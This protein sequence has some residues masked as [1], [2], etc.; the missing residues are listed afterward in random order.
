MEI[1]R[2]TAMNHPILKFTA[3]LACLGAAQLA[4]MLGISTSGGI[5]L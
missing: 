4:G 2:S 1:T 3:L 5:L